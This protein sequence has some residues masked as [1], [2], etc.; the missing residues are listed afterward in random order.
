M[1]EQ[2]NER[3]VSLVIRGTKLTGRMLQK[4]MMK[5]LAEMKKQQ[6]KGKQPKT[7]HGKQ[8]VKELIGQGAGVSS[9][10]ITDDN[11]KSFDR[12][13]RKYG[14]DYS[15]SQDKSET[16]PKW[17]VFFKAR[18]SDALMAAFKEYTAVNL[19]KKDKPSLLES[20]KK[21]I[22]L[23][24]AQTVDRVKNKKQELDR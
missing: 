18:D 5:L 17:L 10:P 23:V 22:E 9:I 1:Q 15:L 14:V 13:A 2:I 21:N 20:L 3:T 6:Q 11:I 7:Y 19:K 24:K 8:S 16:P 4:A 12:V